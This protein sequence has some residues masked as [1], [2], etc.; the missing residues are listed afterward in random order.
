MNGVFFAWFGLLV[1]C[2]YLFPSLNLADF[3]V[4]SGCCYFL[5]ILHSPH[6]TKLP[7]YYRIRFFSSLLHFQSRQFEYCLFI[8][9]MAAFSYDG[10]LESS[11]SFNRSHWLFDGCL[12]IWF[13]SNVSF[14]HLYRL[15]DWLE[16]NNK[17]HTDKQQELHSFISK[18]LWW[19]FRIDKRSQ[20]LT[21]TFF[22]V[23]N[24]KACDFYAYRRPQNNIYLEASKKE[25]LSSKTFQAA[26][27]TDWNVV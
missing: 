14:N 18:Y 24:Q 1:S 22:T 27:K 4:N 21:T 5:F 23:A 10:T 17:M 15:A 19:W 20:K 26:A 13:L 11:Y 8:L 25:T 12:S 2:D 6:S 7:D 3:W 16:L 9:Y